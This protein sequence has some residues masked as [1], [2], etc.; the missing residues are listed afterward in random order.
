VGHDSSAKGL[1]AHFRIFT[2]EKIF[3]TRL[4]VT[5][6]LILMYY[7]MD[8]PVRRFDLRCKLKNSAVICGFRRDADEICVLLRYYAA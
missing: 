3:V 2:I 4:Y 1:C 8:L 6:N 5:I 7:F